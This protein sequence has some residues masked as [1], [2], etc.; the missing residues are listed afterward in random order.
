MD[1]NIFEKIEDLSAKIDKLLPKQE[2]TN[3]HSNEELE[4][5]LSSF[6][7]RSQKSYRYM[8][9]EKKFQHE[10]KQVLIWNVVLLTVLVLS[11][12]FTCLAVNFYTTFTL[13]E[14]IWLIMMIYST[15]YVL[16]AKRVY[17]CVAFSM[18]SFF[19]FQCD[20]LGV[21][22]FGTMKKKYKVFLVLTCI[23]GICNVICLWTE[24]VVGFKIWATILEILLIGL[25]IYVFRFKTVDFFSGYTSLQFTGK[26]NAGTQTVTIVVDLATQEWYPSAEE[27][28]NRF[29]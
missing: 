11:T 14:N 2:Q 20:E 1:K 18:N 17:D 13:F 9:D 4:T 26:N 25:S 8:S 15:I 16:R 22:M 21:L 3:N 19:K 10:R 23:C 27:Y 28:E 7:Q 24:P 29:S 5:V 6:I 12:I